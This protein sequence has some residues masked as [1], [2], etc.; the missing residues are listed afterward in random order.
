MLPFAHSRSCLPFVRMRIA[1]Y[2]LPRNKILLIFSS[3]S[4]T[5]AG[6]FV[7]RLIDC[8]DWAHI[9]MEHYRAKI[10]ST[11]TISYGLLKILL[12]ILIVNHISCNCLAKIFRARDL[13]L[14]QQLKGESSF[15][16]WSLLSNCVL[17]FVAVEQYNSTT[18]HNCISNTIQLRRHNSSR[19]YIYGWIDV[20]VKGFAMSFLLLVSLGGLVPN[21]FANVLFIVHTPSRAL[22]LLQLCVRSFVIRARRLFRMGLPEFQGLEPIHPSRSFKFNQLVGCR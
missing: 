4:I 7:H 21:P 17:V 12:D 15:E 18:I 3:P 13:S 6:K 22:F 10:P 11:Y 16:R 8:I 5:Q 9:Y 20:K 2:V 19:L 1:R 14:C